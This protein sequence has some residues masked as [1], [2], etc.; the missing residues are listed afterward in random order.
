MAL[1]FSKK[2]CKPCGEH[3]LPRKIC[4]RTGKHLELGHLDN[5]LSVN[6]LSP[7]LWMSHLGPSVL[8]LAFCGSGPTCQLYQL[9][10]VL[11]VA[12]TLYTCT[13]PH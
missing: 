1:D 3:N 7:G 11:Q 4:E 2:V 6:I 13:S 9:G 8:E 10:E 5:P 12:Q